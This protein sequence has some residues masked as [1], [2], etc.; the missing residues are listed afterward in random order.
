MIESD[1]NGTNCE[2][3]ATKNE[4]LDLRAVATLR[5][6]KGTHKLMILDDKNEKPAYVST[7]TIPNSSV[8]GT[9]MCTTT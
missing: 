8:T 1:A 5:L 2:I 3:F 6:P 9:Y 4:D 7:I